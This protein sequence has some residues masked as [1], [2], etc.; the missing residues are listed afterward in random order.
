MSFYEPQRM[1]LWRTP[2]PHTYVRHGP[3]GAMV[4]SWPASLRSRGLSRFSSLAQ[5]TG[6]ARPYGFRNHCRDAAN[7]VEMHSQLGHIG[8]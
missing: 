2:S 5:K 1:L 8:D 6:C 4:C 3:E 7:P